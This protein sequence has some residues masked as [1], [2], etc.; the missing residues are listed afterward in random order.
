[1]PRLEV[2]DVREPGVFFLPGGACQRRRLEDVLASV[3]VEEG[4]DA[5]DRVRAV[6]LELLVVERLLLIRERW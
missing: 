5:D 4:V 2:R 6:V 1:M 3:R